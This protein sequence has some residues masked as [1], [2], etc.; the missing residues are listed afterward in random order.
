MLRKC[1]LIIA[2]ALLFSLPLFAQET[3][4][5]FAA[6]GLSW[7]QYAAPQISGN[8]LYAKRIGYQTYSFNFVDVISTSIR[9]FKTA[10][11]ITTGLG[12]RLFVIGKL[13]VWATT[14]VGILAGG[15]E[16]SYSWTSGGAVSIPIGR[17]FSIMPNVR[18]IKNNVTQLQWIGGV[19]FGWGK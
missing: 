9:P 16:A 12:Q 6:L 3:P 19:L 10:T 8:L 11:S 2:L 4:D 1:S 7:N 14:G 5:Q 15:E 17:G 13:G 18:F